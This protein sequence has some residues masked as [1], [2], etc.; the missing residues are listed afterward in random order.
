MGHWYGERIPNLDEQV[1]N[2]GQPLPSSS[3]KN[4]KPLSPLSAEENSSGSNKKRPHLH[5]S[6]TKLRR[7]DKG[8]ESSTSTYSGKKNSALN[9][10]ASPAG[11]KHNTLTQN[12]QATAP[13][14]GSSIEYKSGDVQLQL[15]KNSSVPVPLDTKTG[16]L[17]RQQGL[18]AENNLGR[19]RPPKCNFEEYRNS[20]HHWLKKVALKMKSLGYT[21]EEYNVF[22]ESC[23]LLSFVCSWA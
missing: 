8:S 19:E 6:R 23:G 14:R 10:S 1:N 11:T 3:I 16:K 7:V 12:K 20:P 18:T 21:V 5:S 9:R 15:R 4:G 17:L 13:S 22:Y 2:Y